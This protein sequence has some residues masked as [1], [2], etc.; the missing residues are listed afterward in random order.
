MRVLST[1]LLIAAALTG[2]QA[3]SDDS[4]V[5]PQ[6]STTS[7]GTDGDAAIADNDVCF[8]VWCGALPDGTT[9]IPD[10]WVTKDGV[11][12]APDGNIVKDGAIIE[13]DGAI[14][15]PDGQVIQPDVPIFVP[16]GAILLPDGQIVDPDGTVIEPDVQPCIPTT[17]T[18]NGLDVN[19]DGQIDNGFLC[20]DGQPC[21][22]DNCAGIDGCQHAPAPFATACDLD[23]S[24]C[25]QD[26]CLA[27]KCVAGGV[28]NCGD[29][30]PCTAD[31]CDPTN[32]ACV[33]TPKTGPCDDGNGCTTG[34][35]CQGGCVAGPQKVC[36]DNN[37]CTLDGCDPGTGQCT[38]TPFAA[39]VSCN[40]GSKCT[41]SDQCANGV[42][43]GKPLNC[44]DGLLCTDDLCE[45]TQGCQHPPL[46]GIACNDGLPCTTGDV[47]TGGLCKAQGT[48]GC[49]DGNPCTIDACANAGACSHTATSA[50]CDDGTLCTVGDSCATGV[51]VG[52]QSSCDDANPC[53]TDSCDPKI[54]CVFADNNVPC[55]DGNA[56]TV[57]DACTGGTCLGQGTNCDDGIPCTKDL[58]DAASGGCSHTPD[59]ALCDDGE[60]CTLDACL[61]ATGC[62]HDL[63]PKCC[64][65]SQCAAD[66][67]CI[68][69]P[70]NLQ[71]F[72]AK[73]C[74]SGAD[75]AGSCCYM[76]YTTKHCLTPTYQAECC[77]TTEYWATDAE[78]YGCGVG[79]KG[80]CVNWPNKTPPA[81]PS[82]TVACVNKCTKNS[83]CPGSCCGQD[84]MGTQ[85]CIADGYQSQFCPGF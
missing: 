56:C 82:K 85:N 15:L 37:S 13:P 48:L 2:L 52:K 29:P 8:D 41:Y 33:H 7:G 70:D 75:C 40:D 35:T 26:H 53:T 51:C 69:Y 5:Q 77:G 58:C 25:T 34:D 65:G 46:D 18:C 45:P 81:W 63:I 67:A 64:G 9:V 83:D 39:G 22:V 84:T 60:I 50:A 54:G 23:G 27:G 38:Y 19:C 21:T 62:K 76:T 24:A 36:N 10:Q 55:N 12:V 14:L 1:F 4:G 72:C 80:Q 42:C 16:D 59:K 3:C 32:G 31:S 61:T 68:Q 79:G 74:N 28:P 71:P 43:L 66:E 20:N 57:S 11:V 49:D 47:C 17:E 44:D 78:P 73:T 30:D 6:V